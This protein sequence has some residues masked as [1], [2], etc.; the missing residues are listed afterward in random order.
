M[1][2]VDTKQRISIEI[3]RHVAL[4]LLEALSPVCARIEVAGSI[5]RRMPWIGDIELV[6]IPRYREEPSLLPDE[7]TRIDAL[8]ELVTK[9]VADGDLGKR[10]DAKGRPRFGPKLKYLT[11]QD[12]AVDLFS[13]RAETW[14]VQFTLR[15]GPADYSHQLVTH[16]GKS[17]RDFTGRLRPGLLPRHLLVRDGQL[18]LEGVGLGAPIPTPTE[19]SFFEAIGEPWIPPEERR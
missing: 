10:L 9:L 17:F 5:R 6:A 4:G 1:S 15:T 8:D 3:A 7:P 13:V 18:Q 11:Y 19:E 12:V 2:A 16:Q 14:G